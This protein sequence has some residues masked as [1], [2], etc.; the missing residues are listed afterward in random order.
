MLNFVKD[1]ISEIISFFSD[2][3]APMLSSR[4]ILS[5]SGDQGVELMCIKKRKFLEICEMYP[6]SAKALKYRAFL[7]R[8]FIR[9]QKKKMEDLQHN[10]NL[11]DQRERNS[12]IINEISS[13]QVQMQNFTND[14]LSSIDSEEEDQRD[15][16]DFNAEG[17]RENEERQK[18]LLKKSQDLSV[19]F[20]Y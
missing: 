5:S 15:F 19:T 7:R 14:D 12:R 1:L 13:G 6:N 3:E 10:K 11:V 18:D 20:Y 16:M 2:S 9:K 17:A 8:K 4:F